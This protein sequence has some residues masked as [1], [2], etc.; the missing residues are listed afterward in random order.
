FIG[1]LAGFFSFGFVAAALL[2]RFVVA[3]SPDGWRI[4]QLLT[5]LPILM[6]LWWRRALP[7]SPRYLLTQG[8]EAEAEAVVHALEREVEQATGR[9]L[10]PLAVQDTAAAPQKNAGS[11]DALRFLWSASMA[12]R[13]AIVWLLWFVQTFSYYGFF[14]WIPT[15]LVQRGI[16]VTRSFEYSIVVYLAQVPGYFSA[17]WSSEHIDRKRTM[18]LYLS[19]AAICALWLSRTTTGSTIT[20]AGA[21]LSFFLNG[22]WAALYAYTP[23]VFPTW[24]RATGMGLSSACGRIGGVIAPML[25]GVFAERLGFAGVFAVTTT[26]LAAGVLTVSLFGLSTAGQSLEALSGEL[27]PAAERAIPSH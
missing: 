5:A 22:T 4:A 10:A 26:M 21:A 11:A 1:T 2:G 6:L 25:I 18:G 15:L 17:A 12:R 3:A 27:Q 19:G 14:T 20:M 7:E 13:T 24:V 16:T 23:E 8:R 9:A